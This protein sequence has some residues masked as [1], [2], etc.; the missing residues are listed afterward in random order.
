MVRSVLFSLA[1]ACAGAEPLGLLQVGAAAKSGMMTDKVNSL[2]KMAA[3]F[4]ETATNVAA[5]KA[6]EM[7]SSVDLN[8][9][10]DLMVEVKDEAKAQH[11]A[12]EARLAD[13]VEKVEDLQA[14]RDDWIANTT[15]P[16][17]GATYVNTSGVTYNAQHTTG[18]VVHAMA[19]VDYHWDL[20]L[21]K[22]DEH[23]GARSSESD[24][25]DAWIQ[26]IDDTDSFRND[27]IGANHPSNLAACVSGSTPAD[28][29]TCLDHVNEW[30]STGLRCQNLEGYISDRDDAE[31]A[32]GDSQD[33][34]VAAQEAM[35]AEF[36]AFADHY[37]T[38]CNLYQQE[39]EEAKV[40]FAGQVEDAKTIQT[41]IL[42]LVAAA[43][44]VSCYVDVIESMNTDTTIEDCGTVVTG[45]CLEE[46]ITCLADNDSGATLPDGTELS[47]CSFSDT[48]QPTAP[49]DLD[50]FT[51][52]YLQPYYI[53]VPNFPD[54]TPCDTARIDTTPSDGASGWTY[55]GAAHLTCTPL[56]CP[57]DPLTSKLTTITIGELV[58]GA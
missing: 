32:Y 7:P 40:T 22:K 48:C 24:A 50:L 56:A 17:A 41:N 35:E 20:F 42:V 1:T 53:T 55:N 29:K 12:E 45:D 26:H 2:M 34:A 52:A 10:R 27:C 47:S 39:Y 3:S 5:G 37:I 11:D 49:L 19:G 18:G 6:K 31:T 4:K 57:S 54:W 38:I 44:K 21:Q 58:D 15:A 30:A 51:V 28:A 33:A 13:T 46:M 36:W 8:D 25:L 23:C 9:I 14:T 16:V 43:T